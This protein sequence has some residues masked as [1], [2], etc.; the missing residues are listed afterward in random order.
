MDEPG[1][2]PTITAAANTNLR[3]RQPIQPGPMDGR[4]A[5]V[6]AKMLEKLHYTRHAFD[7][8]I[9]G[10]FLDSYLEALDPQ[11]IHFLQEDLKEFEKYRTRLD[12][13]T[14]AGS[15]V[16][17]VRP[18][19]DIYNRLIKRLEQ[20]LACVEELLKTEPFKFDTDEKILINRKELPYP[21][22]LAEAEI[23]WRE[24][25]RFEYLQE[26][27]RK[28]RRPT[29]KRKRKTRSGKKPA[30]DARTRRRRKPSARRSWTRFHTA[31]TAT[32]SMFRDWD[33]D[34]VLQLYLTALAHVYD[35]HSDY[36]GQAQ[37]DSLPSA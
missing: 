5:F 25:L 6:T 19:C 35:P 27:L 26:H 36:F 37:L 21:K 31:I 20:R 24:R 17:D 32:C 23:L 18:S 2:P 13:L 34:D 33:N 16:A 30:A 15:G 28:N 1:S 10:K 3:F 14:L 12:D 9:S 29:R 4:I 8:E 22:D 7:D 11:H